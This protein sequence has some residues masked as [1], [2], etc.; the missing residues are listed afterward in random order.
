MS[1]SMTS[2][3]AWV[4]ELYE[5]GIITEEETDGLSLEWGSPEAII[6][7]IQQVIEKRGIG[8]LLARGWIE[9]AKAIGRNI[10]RIESSV[11]QIK[12]YK[13]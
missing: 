5:K 12:L 6:G 3:T 13:L 11:R 4:M 2:Y 1:C 8:K 7:L 9:A 10:Y